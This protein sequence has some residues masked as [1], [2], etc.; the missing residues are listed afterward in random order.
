MIVTAR[1]LNRATL[2]RQM[3][4]RREKLGVGEAVRRA[5]ALQAQEPAS[6]YVA[7]WNRIDGFDPADLDAAFAAREVV[8]ATLMR[9][10]LQ[11]VHTDDYRSSREAVD[12]T[13]RSGQLDARFRAS[14]L[15]PADADALI[16][17]LL[18]HAE[19]TR[20]SAEVEAWLG[21]R[22]GAA[23]HPGALRGFGDT[24]RCCTRRPGAVGVRLAQRVHRR[25]VAA[26][27]R[28][29]RR[30][31]SGLANPGRA[32]P[33]RVRAGLNRGRGAVRPRAAG[34]GQGGGAGAGRP[35]GAA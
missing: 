24:R 16:P 25:D 10:T 3:L 4:L 19:Q 28:R 18:A 7:L 1:G 11:A 20:T 34:A 13:L 30:L 12:P 2:A 33:G 15:A 21:Q 6:P 14:G 8:K 31:R 35:S 22:L 9:I 26:G 27:P 5:V 29:H 32:L 23:P 17:D